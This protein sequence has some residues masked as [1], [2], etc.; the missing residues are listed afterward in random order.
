MLVPRVLP[1][2]RRLVPVSRLPLDTVDSGSFRLVQVHCL[3][4]EG[5][6]LDRLEVGLQF[7]GLSLANEGEVVLCS[8]ESLGVGLRVEGSDGLDAI[9][10]IGPESDRLCPADKFL[11]G[12]RLN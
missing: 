1:S 5:F 4:E 6:L 3:I 2:V 12:D 11:E 9:G 7:V 8:V 10:G